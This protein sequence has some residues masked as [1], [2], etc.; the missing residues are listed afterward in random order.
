MRATAALLLLCLLGAGGPALAAD[1][2]ARRAAT[3]HFRAGRALFADGRWADALSEFEA[4]YQQFPLPGFQ[5]NIGQC[6][7]KLERLQDA[8]A[9]FT[10]FLDAPRADPSLRAEVQEALDEVNAALR[11][12]A[13]AAAEQ[14][15]RR[16]EEKTRE[17]NALLA[18]IDPGIH[19]APA[20]APARTVEP[21]PAVVPAAALT[22]E[23]PPPAAGK[24]RARW[25]VWTLVG[26]AVAGAVTAGTVA[27]LET[28][29][30]AP[31]AGSLGLLDGR[32]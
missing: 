23:A 24:K 32:R 20:R 9:A 26:V 29:P 12:E 30:A 7:R 21:A 27:V 16:E 18:S 2:Q 8:A 22:V 10:R 11:R 1:A 13:D 19:A 17:R 5:V 31:R 3:E 25:W 15:R 4:G 28:Q 14:A 6:Y